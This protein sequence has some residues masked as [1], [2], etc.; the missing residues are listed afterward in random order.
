MI[1]CHRCGAENASGTTA[2]RS[3][4]SPLIDVKKNI[5]PEQSHSEKSF[6]VDFPKL[7]QEALPSIVAIGVEFVD[8][9]KQAIV[10]G[11]GSGYILDGGFVVTN[12]HVVEQPLIRSITATFDPSID[13]VTYDLRIVEIVPEADVAILRFTGLM[14]KVM[15]RKKH[16]TLRTTPL[17][18]GEDVY[19]IGNPLDLGLSTNLGVV[20]CPSREFEHRG[21]RRYVQISFPLNPGNS[22]GALLDF[23]NQ[24]V[25]MTTMGFP[26]PGADM[27][28][29]A[30]EISKIIEKIK[31]IGEES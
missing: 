19:T 1:I 7:V 29:P 16:L 23:Q 20:S 4:R 9:K 28:V 6:E 31:L 12:S 15:S 24:V 2:C 11:A 27:C 3:C 14:D 17:K 10:G 25:G 26:K 13:S 8:L 21:L 22:G 30:C 18:M 5:I